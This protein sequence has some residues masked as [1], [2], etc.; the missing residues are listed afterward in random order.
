VRHIGDAAEA[1]SLLNAGY[2]T[3]DQIS[4]YV[5]LGGSGGETSLRKLLALAPTEW[6]ELG[7]FTTRIQEQVRRGNRVLLVG[8]SEGTIFTNLIMRFLKQT[9]P[10]VA[11]SVGTLDIAAM[12]SSLEDTSIHGAAY[13]TL[14]NDAVANLVRKV[15]FD[16]LTANTANST[17]FNQSNGL[18]N[19]TEWTLP[20]TEIRQ[21]IIFNGSIETHSLLKAYLNVEK[22]KD[23]N[24][25]D[26]VGGTSG[27]II[28]SKA[29][30]KFA[31]LET[32]ISELNTGPFTATLNWGA[33]PDVDL[34]IFEPTGTHVYYW[35]KVGDAGYL[36]RDDTNGY[37]PEHYYT[38]CSNV[39]E[40]VYTIG[41]NYYSGS[42]PETATV[43][44]NYGS[45]VYSVKNIALQSSRGSSGNNSPDVIVQVRVQKDLSGAI[46]ISVE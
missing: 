22:E 1:N 10:D 21:R 6:R 42:L 12:V 26:I 11:R 39:Q 36:D 23:G 15:K 14:D 13:V 34:H 28:L 8:Y 31:T 29:V 43:Q 20:F 18:K 3:V 41:I 5:Q 35:N 16:T 24:V 40:G 25:V 2:Q 27:L 4:A 45:T 17:A 46:D 7:D 30:N 32:P 37:G 44:I 33:N 9:A 38:D 19:Y